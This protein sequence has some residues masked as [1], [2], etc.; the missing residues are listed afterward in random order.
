ML[1]VL[2]IVIN[3]TTGQATLWESAPM[4]EAQ[5]LATQSA[6]WSHD[7]PTVTATAQTDRYQRR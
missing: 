2:A 6:I 4:P 7:V 5:C 1:L 3:T